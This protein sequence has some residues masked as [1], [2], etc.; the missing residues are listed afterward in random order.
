MPNRRSLEVLLK[1][2]AAVL[3]MAV[4]Y[5]LADFAID[6][7]PAGI[8]N[9]YRF[10]V[11]E[12]DSDQVRILQRDSLSILV[13]RRSDSTISNLKQG[14]GNLQDPTSS[15]SNQPEFARNALR[16]K[17]PEIFVSYALGTDLGCTL[18]VLQNQ[19][20]EIC[21]NARYDFAGRALDSDKAFQNLVVPDYNF[22]NDFR[23]LTI[24]P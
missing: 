10:K 1:Y 12:L 16:S 24:R 9:S 21:G 5:I 6:L 8:Q 2:F 23:T 15:R 11:G 14:F 4:L 7:R 18:E 17:H 22:S 20:K 13:I 3:G 19:L